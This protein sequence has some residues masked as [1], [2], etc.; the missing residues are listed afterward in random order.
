MFFSLKDSQPKLRLQERRQLRHHRQ[1]PP[2]MSEVPLQPMPDDRHEPRR[3]S[4]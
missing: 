1:D 3:R 4:G 2:A